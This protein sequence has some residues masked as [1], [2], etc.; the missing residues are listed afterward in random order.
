[1]LDNVQLSHT[2]AALLTHASVPHACP[3]TKGAKRAA[4][5]CPW[6]HSSHQ[7]I[8]RHTH[9]T[10]IYH[11]VGRPVLIGSA[12]ENVAAADKVSNRAAWDGQAA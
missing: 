10:R 9:R 7:S 6:R 11:N 4:A 12:E 8:R 3:T 1:M 5:R 2:C